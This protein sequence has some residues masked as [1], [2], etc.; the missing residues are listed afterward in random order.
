MNQQLADKKPYTTPTLEQLGDAETL[1][2]MPKM[3]GI[4][5]AGIEWGNGPIPS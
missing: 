1:T 3:I 2:G 5:D 4:G